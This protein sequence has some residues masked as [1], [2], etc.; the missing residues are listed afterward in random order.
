[1]GNPYRTIDLAVV[2][3]MG[4]LS[5]PLHRCD[6]PKSNSDRTLILLSTNPNQIASLSKA[7]YYRIRQLRSIWPY[8]D[9]ST[10]CTIATSVVQPN[11]ITIILSIINS[12][13]L[14]YPVSSRSRTLAHSLLSVKLLS[15]VISLQS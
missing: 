13:S 14:N 1:M 12:L 7:C 11:L 5:I 9:S 6:Q 8:L 2:C 3:S 15:P 4:I 10:V